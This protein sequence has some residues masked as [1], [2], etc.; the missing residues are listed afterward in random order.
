MNSEQVVRGYRIVGDRKPD[1]QLS[2][3]YLRLE[4]KAA[5]ALANLKEAQR[6]KGSN[7]AGREDEFSGETLMDDREAFMQCAGCPVWTECDIFRRV[8][9]PSWGTW[10]GVVKG[11]GDMENVE[12]DFND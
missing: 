11:R 9:H 5:H 7:C 3:D 10:A 8:G 1:R 6:T 4:P 2:F 12:E